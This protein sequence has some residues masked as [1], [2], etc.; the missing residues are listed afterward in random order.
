MSHPNNSKF[1]Y[2]IAW[3]KKDF[4]KYYPA[5]ANYKKALEE[6][7]KAIGEKQAQIW[8]DFLSKL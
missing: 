7:S 8:A 4:G 6:K 1:Y 2:H 3:I 5:I